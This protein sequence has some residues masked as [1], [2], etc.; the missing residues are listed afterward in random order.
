MAEQ[1]YTIFQ[2]LKLNKKKKKNIDTDKEIYISI[3]KPI[4]NNEIDDKPKKCGGYLTIKKK[5]KCNKKKC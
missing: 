3:N 5:K 2:N 4:H 1:K